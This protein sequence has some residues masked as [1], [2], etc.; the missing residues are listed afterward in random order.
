MLDLC[1]WRG[2]RSRARLTRRCF[3]RTLFRLRV[4]SHFLAHA[5]TVALVRQEK[6]S[7]FD[8]A[9]FFLE[10]V[11]QQV[12][13]VHLRSGRPGDQLGP[14]A[15]AVVAAGEALLQL[16]SACAEPHCSP[17]CGCRPSAIY[18]LRCMYEP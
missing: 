13:A 2:R 5:S 8:A 15:A 16:V 1:C 9:V 4:E 14:T 10:S 12:C 3:S 11:L 7:T 17:G 18:W 6:Q